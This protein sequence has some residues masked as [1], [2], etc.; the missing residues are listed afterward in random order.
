MNTCFL[1]Q[2][3][4]SRVSELGQVDFKTI[5]ENLFCL[6]PQ[7]FL[8]IGCFLPTLTPTQIIPLGILTET[9]L[10]ILLHSPI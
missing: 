5:A 8:Q 4:L 2:W 9:P 6:R 7:D 1:T 10:E 3:F